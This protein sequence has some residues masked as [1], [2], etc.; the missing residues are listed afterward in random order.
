MATAAM[1]RSLKIWD[2]RNTYKCLADYKLPGQSGAAHL[3]VGRPVIA[4][5]YKF[6]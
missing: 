2:V 5:N 1:D 6:K 3:Q 4:S